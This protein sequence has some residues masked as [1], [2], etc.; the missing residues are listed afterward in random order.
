MATDTLVEKV[1]KNEIPD[2]IID[3]EILESLYSKDIN[4]VYVDALTSLTDFSDSVISDWLNLS[5][6]TLREYRKPSSSFK[7]NV[8]EHVLVLLTLIKH[9][10]AAL[11]SQKQFDAWLDTP[12]FYFDKKKPSAFLNTVTGVKFVDDRLTAM[13]Y[14]D[15]V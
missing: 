14:G 4:W 3:G 15:N 10:R 9:G 13:E 6:K 11:G 12:N 2:H 8:K 5:V 1:V 7:D